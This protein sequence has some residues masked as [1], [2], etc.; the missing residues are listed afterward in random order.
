MGFGV[1]RVKEA[2]TV[3][4]HRL[5]LNVLKFYMMDNNWC[6]AK[7]F[8]VERALQK[9]CS[10]SKIRRLLTV[11]VWLGRGNLIQK[12]TLETLYMNDLGHVFA[13]CVLQ[14]P[15]TCFSKI[16]SVQVHTISSYSLKE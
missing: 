11:I 4:A 5:R 7:T 15:I 16:K 12:Q 6:A 10:G 2:G 9:F 13:V 14:F 8:L 1:E 3:S